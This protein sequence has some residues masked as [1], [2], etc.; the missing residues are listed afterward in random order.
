MG[1]LLKILFDWCI[2]MLDFAHIDSIIEPQLSGEQLSVNT[3][4]DSPRVNIIIIASTVSFVAMLLLLYLL[5]YW[6]YQSYES[7]FKQLFGSFLYYYEKHLK[8][9]MQTMS[10]NYDI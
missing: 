6:R 8:R 1:A 4:Y 3:L 9:K 5:W 10:I 2:H 7:N